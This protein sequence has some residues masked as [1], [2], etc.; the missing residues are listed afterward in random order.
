[1]A[2]DSV[3]RDIRYAFRQIRRTPLVAAAVVA[4]AAI[5]I[6]G[7][8]TIFS[9]VKAT[10]LGSL[11]VPEP[12]RVVAMY[13]GP[14]M[15]TVSYPAY[16]QFRDSGVFENLSG[17]FPLV[18]ASLNDGGEPER[19]W[20]QIT[21]ANYF[22]AT[23]VPMEVGRGFAAGEENERVVVLSHSLWVRR[24]HADRGVIGRMVHIND[25]LYTVVGVTQRGF[26]GTIRGLLSEFWAPLGMHDKIL[27]RDQRSEGRMTSLDHS[28]LIL[29]GRLK[30]GMSREK[31][32]AILNGIEKRIRAERRLEGEGDPV[33]VEPAGGLPVGMQQAG[34]T[35]A[36][37]MAVSG[38]VLLIACANVANLLLARAVA[39]QREMSVR[40][41]IGAGRGRLI[42][43]LLTESV[44]LAMMGA[45]AGMFLTWG[46]SRGLQNM[47]LPIPLPL[48]LDF[49]PDVRVL[50]FAIALAVVTGVVFGLA[51]ALRG[52][53]SV[54]AGMK[55]DTTAFGGLR[56]WSLSQVLVTGQVTLTVVLLVGC[57]LF[58]R[59]L[60][61]AASVKLGFDASNMLIAAVDPR[62]HGYDKART[63]SMM[64]SLR[65]RLSRQPGVEGVAFSDTVP[66]T[67]AGSRRT[68]RG[69]ENREGTVG[70]Y[71]VSRGYFSMLRVPI[72]AGEDL[73]ERATA[74]R[75]R[76]VINT[77]A[78]RLLFGRENA[79]G[80]VVRMGDEECEVAGVAATIKDRMLSE[81][82]QAILYEPLLEASSDASTFT[83]ITMLV[84]TMGAAEQAAPLVRQVVRE[85]DSNLAVFNVSTMAEQVRRAM[86]L[87][88][89]AATL[90]AVFGVTG[91]VLS[92]VG[93]FGL[94]SYAVRRRTKEIGIRVA[95]GAS[96]A[97]VMRLASVQGLVIAGVGLALGS[98]MAWGLSRVLE[99]FLFGV[100][101]RDLLVFAAMPVL[102]L[103]VALGAILAPAWRAARVSPLEA[104]RN[105]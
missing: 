62:I 93:L 77:E 25:G 48:G 69:T 2:I 4:S 46:A 80:A 13:A 101:A 29:V 37:L 103:G 67:L 98:G 68:A 36:I 22:A 55:A 95:L 34:L 7:N 94:M 105:E 16:R 70:L 23:R 40:L 47:R 79:V 50:A 31:A 53:R 56:R 38:M 58:V 84:R 6:A 64:A 12:D 57:G 41:A 102:L 21:T 76:V 5:G 74:G 35:M 19:L 91:L 86:L 100:D 96:P 39:R 82:P 15:D 87:P 54:A 83:G 85:L 33:Y 26:H 9:A 45:A 92:M 18:P 3:V 49:A 11:P 97:G 44:V 42:R 52:T 99:S 60:E 72:V 43:Q 30:E 10:L 71:G 59:S 104:L 27:P 66:L 51:P 63:E 65:E 28:W 90:F 75:K 61:K 24:F 81:S 14:A 78:A 20:G 88:R 73:P 17:F 89:V 32:A 8:A 1:M